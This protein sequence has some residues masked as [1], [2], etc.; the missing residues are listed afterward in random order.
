MTLSAQRSGTNPDEA[1]V[2]ITYGPVTA[3]VTEHKSHLRSFHS[4]LG[5]L[6]DH[7]EKEQPLPEVQ[8]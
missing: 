8:D 2:R 6:L 5:S 3:E 7:M 1:T 4:M